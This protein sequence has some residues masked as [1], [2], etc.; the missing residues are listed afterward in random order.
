MPI[1]QFQEDGMSDEIVATG[2]SSAQYKSHDEGQFVGQQV[3][4]IAL[5]E[6]VEDFPGTSPKLTPKCALVFRTGEKNELGDFIDVSKEFSVSM[7]EKA[8]L[9]KFLEQWRGK[10]YTEEQVKEG[11]PLHK[12]TGNYALLTVSHKTSKAGRTYAAIEACVGVPKQMQ[13]GLPNYLP[14]Y[15]RAD[16]WET[17]KQEYAE[18]ARRFR[19]EQHNGSDPDDDSYRGPFDESDD[20]P[21]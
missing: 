11:V 6:K 20:L 15:K 14:D 1:L 18:A 3:D 10:T 7:N 16:Y 13:Q 17:R 2:N 4:T 5:G 21:F 12:L 9:R 19:G 8:N